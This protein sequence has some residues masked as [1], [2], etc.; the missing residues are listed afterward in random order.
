M[1]AARAADQPVRIQTRDLCLDTR[2]AKAISLTRTDD[3]FRLAMLRSFLCPP[4]TAS[5][6]RYPLTGYGYLLEE[7]VITH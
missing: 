3:F 4:Q 6:Y 7:I 5:F 2:S 1:C